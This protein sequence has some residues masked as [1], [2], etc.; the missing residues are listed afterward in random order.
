MK[1]TALFTARRGRSFLAALSQ[2]EGRNFQFE[3]LRPT[4][5]LFG[6]FNLLVEQYKQVMNP[7][8]EVMEAVTEH[9]EP[10]G[11]WVLLEKV[12][13]YAEWER[14]KK[15]REKKRED[16]KELERRAF[17]EIDWHD[18]A[19]VQTIEFT[20]ADAATELPAPMSIAEVESMTLA[21]KQMAAM[22]MED[23]EEDVEALRVK[24]AAAD[25]EASKAAR[26]DVDMDDEDAEARERRRRDEEERERELQRARAVQ[27]TSL[28]AG[29]P[30][31]IR[32]DYVPKSACHL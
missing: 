10:K 4:H 13:E 17:A 22:I 21:Q 9:A 16:E 5:S 28:D 11:K 8:K 1:L 15:E 3:F 32:T 7:R 19:I 31:K 24:Q 27:A 30:M 25:A 18:Y 14:N 23:A 12:R 29:G 26:V 6:Y 20:Q 2:R